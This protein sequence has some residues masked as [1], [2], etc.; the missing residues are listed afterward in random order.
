MVLRS[1]ELANQAEIER[2][3]NL[4]SNIGKG[5]GTAASLATA[6]TLGP[7]A[8]KIMPFLNEYI[9]AG[10]ALKGINK[11]SPKL[12]AFLSKG[13]EMGLDLESGL[14]YVKDKFGSVKEKKEQAKENRNIIEQESPELHQFISQ[15][16]AK[17]RPPLH[18]GG[19]AQQ[20]KRFSE[21]IKKLSKKHKTDW[22]KIIEA[23]YGQEAKALPEQQQQATQPQGIQ[24]QQPQP[25]QQQVQSQQQAGQGQQALMAVL[26]KINQ[27]LG[28]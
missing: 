1:D 26:Q 17:G 13:Q 21:V 3:K 12:G 2:D 23:I 22:S 15:E 14:D 6:S 5:I 16:I 20:D 25:G 11:V 10:L 9:P 18:A 19:I 24:P 8:S 4:R 7:L 28:S 27:R